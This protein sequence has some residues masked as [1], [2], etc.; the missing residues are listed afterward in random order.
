MAD[1]SRD[2]EFRLTVVRDANAKQRAE[3]FER[4]M[5]KANK[6]YEESRV[7][8][9]K[10]SDEDINRQRG[11][12]VA[13]ERKAQAQQEREGRAALNRRL[14]EYKRAKAEEVRLT[15][16]AENQ[17][18]EEMRKSAAYQAG[19]TLAAARRGGA[20]SGARAGS[21]VGSIA[22]AGLL[23]AGLLK[24]ATNPAAL[25]AT[26]VG[27]GAVRT[28]QVAVGKFSEFEALQFRLEALVGSAQ[29]ARNVIDK[30]KSTA[31]ATGVRLSGLSQATTMML[32]FNVSAEEAT[33]KLQEMAVIVG[34]DSNRLDRLALAYS[35]AAAQG[36]LMG[37]ELNQMIDAG[38]NPLLSISAK[39]GKSVR[40][41]RDIMRDGRLEFSLVS[42]AF[43]D[44]TSA[45]GQYGD[46][47]ERMQQS[48]QVAFGQMSQAWDELYIA[49]GRAITRAGVTDANRFTSKAVSSAAN[50]IDFVASSNND[51][52]KQRAFEAQARLSAQTQEGVA[53]KDLT[54]EARQGR[55][56]I[57]LDAQIEKHASRLAEIDKRSAQ[58]RMEIANFEKTTRENAIKLA[59]QEA[60]EARKVN[61]IRLSGASKE[62]EMRKKSLET[63][64][65]ATQTAQSALLTAQERFG[66]LS[67]EEQDQAIRVL[68]RARRGGVQG[69]T[70]DELA[71]LG[72]IGTKEAQA[73]QSA[74][75]RQR[76]SAAF[77]NDGAALQSVL[78]Q[79]TII[80]ETIRSIQKQAKPEYNE[81]GQQTGTR[82]TRDQQER[83]RQL[84]A[85][86]NSLGFRQTDLQTREEQRRQLRASLFGQ[87]RQD[88]RRAQFEQ[89]KIEADIKQTVQFIAKYENT[90]QQIAEQ[91]GR[92]MV[93]ASQEQLTEVTKL[94]KPI[95]QQIQQLQRRQLANNPGRGV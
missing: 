26:V 68:D 32:G 19:A 90:S 76:A 5:A 45:G 22:G 85:Q 60:V 78:G 23:S 86:D 92:L 12:A 6:A 20:G 52:A 55:R 16:A 75:Y 62:L 50:M 24:L 71:K 10:K 2:I 13:A 80:A 4:D 14:A 1:S 91:V 49:M 7:K 42:Q 37:E 79:R 29:K 27:A 56:A 39:T 25:A 95:Q 41:L 83:I 51:P 66:S 47:M 18:R 67:K 11:L 94:L 87:E 21:S 54:G 38:F 3:Q 36:R 28:G 34:G 30:L 70:L 93:E 69:M 63:A 31:N 81:L 88:I 9:R 74:G 8:N 15:R 48:T 61:D 53:Y 65:Q 46:A 89:T 44:V 57:E 17:K 33:A 58:R 35:Q 82:L 64:K 40:E 73:L 77:G 43:T 59:A 72:S 84:R